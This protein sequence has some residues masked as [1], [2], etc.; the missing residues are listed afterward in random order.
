MTHTDR[1]PNPLRRTSARLGGALAML[2]L[3]G[4]LFA[5][6]ASATFEQVDTFGDEAG[7][8]RHLL[9]SRQGAAVN[10]SGAGGV[11]AGTLYTGST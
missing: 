8:P 5:T 7:D 9:T 6:T 3:A 10:V 1:T 2:L 11:P 4:F